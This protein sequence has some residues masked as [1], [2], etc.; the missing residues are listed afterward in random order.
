MWWLIFCFHPDWIKEYLRLCWKLSACASGWERERGEGGDWEEEREEE[1]GR[2]RD[3]ER[4]GEGG[5]V[6][7]R[8]REINPEL[9][10]ERGSYAL[11]VDNITPWD[12]IPD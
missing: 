12:D 11:N 3:R 7:E 5:R 2:G 1:R 10:T 9:L 6:E 4:E 8:E